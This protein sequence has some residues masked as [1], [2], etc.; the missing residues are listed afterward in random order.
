MWHSF[1]WRFPGGAPHPSVLPRVIRDHR[2][3][4]RGISLGGKTVPA[5]HS[6][7]CAHVKR[8]HFTGVRRVSPRFFQEFPLEYPNRLAPRR[9]D[10]VMPVVI[11]DYVL[12][13][14]ARRAEDLAPR[15]A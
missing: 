1:L 5:V 7:R 3:P 2:L 12:L 9:V 8:R 13:W 6:L 15:G 4:A 14:R 10:R 11:T